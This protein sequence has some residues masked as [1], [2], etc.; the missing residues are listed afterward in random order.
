LAALDTYSRDH[1]FNIGF[2]YLGCWLSPRGLGWIRNWERDSLMHALSEYEAINAMITSCLDGM[3]NPN[4]IEWMRMLDNRIACSVLHIRLIGHLLDIASFVDDE[5]PELVSEDQRRVANEHLS[6]AERL[7]AE[8][9]ALHVERMPDRA[10]EGT[11]VS[12]YAVIPAYI[13]HIRS[14][15]LR[16]EEPCNHRLSSWDT[17]PAPDQKAK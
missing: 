4:G 16:G 15:F 13:D 17:V 2:C 5:H 14:C 12:Y 6:H 7:A 9:M 3:D 11:L 10:C 1:L 8:Y